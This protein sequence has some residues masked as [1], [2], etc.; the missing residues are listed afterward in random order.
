MYA[1]DG[2]S[3]TVEIKGNDLSLKC[4]DSVFA[5]QFR[6]RTMN[7]W[8]VNSFEDAL[9]KKVQWGIVHGRAHSGSEQCAK[10][11]V[12]LA[13]GKLIDMKAISEQVRKDLSTEEAE[14]EG[15]V[16][17]EKV[18]EGILAIVSKDQSANQKFCYIFNSWEH[19][20]AS[21]FLNKIGGEFG[22]PN[23]CIYCHADKKTIEDR[24]KKANEV[25]DVGEEAQ[26]E[27]A[28][29]AQK[30]SDNQAAF[31][32]LFEDGGISK[33]LHKVSTETMEG[34]MQQ[35]RDI[36]SA[37]VILVQHEKRLDVDTVCSNLA[38]KY[39]YLFISVY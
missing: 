21:E 12:E 26:G 3:P 17:I 27:L 9:G 5:K 13:K 19:K 35:L 6:L 28:E 16:P 38:I 31:D 25:D 29:Q 32:A 11:L 2:A 20:D 8:D 24:Y 15:E 39:N 18:E 4:L 30:D 22:L 34:A 33:N 36:F 10:S 1:T 37:R 7:D 14:Y 23:F